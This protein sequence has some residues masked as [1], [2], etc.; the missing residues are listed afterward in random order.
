[1]TARIVFTAHLRLVPTDKGGRKSPI[2]SNYRPSFDLGGMW[3]GLPTL[4]DG[5]V[6]LVEREELAPDEEGTIR[7]EPLSEEFWGAIRSGMTIAMQEGARVVGWATISEVT[8]AEGFSP[9]VATFV[10]HAREFC[11]F[12]EKAGTLAVSDRM[13]SARRLLLALYTAALV[14]PS[15]E[16]PEGMKATRS[17]HPPVNWSGFDAFE[18]YWEIFDPCDLQEPAAGSLSDDPSC[19]GR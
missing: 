19:R 14:L 4:N 9:A 8:R 18:T 16:A 10:C 13:Q 17:P 1:V 3:Q 6:M 5:R 7:I 11:R 2:R 12:V 15:I